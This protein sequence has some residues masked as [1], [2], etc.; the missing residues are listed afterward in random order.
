MPKKRR[1]RGRT[2][3][4]KGRASYV[5]CCQCGQLV[6]RDKAKKV[7]RY[8][9]LVDRTI[10]RELKAQG[11]FISSP[12]IERW[13]CVSCAVHRGI[14]KVRAKLKRHHYRKF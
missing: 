6:P 9:S 5:Q 12:R 8:A 3:G 13:Y 1:S 4:G 2:K 10:Y 14:V 11:A 7:T